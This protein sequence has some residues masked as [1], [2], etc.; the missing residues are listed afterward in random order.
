MRASFASFHVSWIAV[1]VYAIVFDWE[2]G[3]L[4]F[5]TGLFAGLF[6]VMVT[7][8][9]DGD[10]RFIAPII[11]GLAC[12]VS[13]AWVG[14]SSA[15]AEG[16]ARFMLTLFFVGVVSGVVAGAC[17]AGRKAAPPK[18]ATAETGRESLR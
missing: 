11:V 17:V 9:L 15:E 1:T 6:S 3:W 16:I 14:M 12:V 4:G 2:T 8:L 13:Y 5:G 18:E 7:K 10:K